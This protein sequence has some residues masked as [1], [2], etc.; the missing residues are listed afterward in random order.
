[1][2]ENRQIIAKNIDVNQGLLRRFEILISIPNI[3]QATVSLILIEMPE[4][5]TIT[6]KQGASLAGLT[7]ISRQLNK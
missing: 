5:G 7:P 4:L 6:Q 3:N 1:M 2:K